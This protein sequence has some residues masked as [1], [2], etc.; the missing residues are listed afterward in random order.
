MALQVGDPSC[1]RSSA[2]MRG[3]GTDRRLTLH[4]NSTQTWPSALRGRGG[5]PHRLCVTRPGVATDTRVRKVRPYDY[6]Y[7]YAGYVYADVTPGPGPASA[8]RAYDYDYADVTA[9][10]RRHVT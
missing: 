9:R 6:V 2:G 5:L 10:R 7:A 4:H 3:L 8:A 1:K